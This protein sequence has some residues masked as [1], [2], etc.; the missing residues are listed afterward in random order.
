MPTPVMNT[1][2]SAVPRTRSS[3][4]RSGSSGCGLRPC[5]QTNAVSRTAA[6][7]RKPRVCT[8]CQLCEP[9]LARP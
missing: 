5:H 7:A 6:V 1:D 4:I 8:D 3:K 9:A 2:V